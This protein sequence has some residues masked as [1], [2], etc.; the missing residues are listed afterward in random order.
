MAINP[1]T[2][3]PIEPKKLDWF[4]NMEQ[5]YVLDGDD[6]LDKATG[7]YIKDNDVVAALNKSNRIA[8]KLM[9]HYWSICYHAGLYVMG[10]CQKAELA[11][12]LEARDELIKEYEELTY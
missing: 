8:V 10:G 6:I 4:K 9:R 7:K 1:F 3:K 2:N 12:E 5:R 11:K